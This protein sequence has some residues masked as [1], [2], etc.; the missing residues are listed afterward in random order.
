MLVA[1]RESE[2]VFENTVYRTHCMDVTVKEYEHRKDGCRGIKPELTL[3]SS[4]N[5]DLASMSLM[6]PLGL[7]LEQPP[8]LSPRSL[9]AR[10]AKQRDRQYVMPGEPGAL[11]LRLESVAPRAATLHPSV[12]GR[13]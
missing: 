13:F 7:D 5:W 4:P 11:L 2:H 9:V 8:L 3:H 10:A 6:P 12:I 1:L